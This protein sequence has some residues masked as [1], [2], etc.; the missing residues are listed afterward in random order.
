M[1]THKEKNIYEVI[2]ETNDL[3]KYC[4]S[5]GVNLVSIGISY[6]DNSPFTGANN[7]FRIDKNEPDYW[8]DHSL[9]KGGDVIDFCAL[10]KHDGDKHAALLELAPE[11]YSAKIDKY[12]RDKQSVQDYIM[13]A[14]KNIPEYII[15]YLESRC[16]DREQINR[17][18][19][20]CRAELF[21]NWLVIPRVNY[22]GDFQYYRLRRAPDEQGNENETLQPEKYKCAYIGDNS[23]LKNIPLGIQTLDRKIKYLVIVEG[24]FDYLNFERERFAVIGTGGSSGITKEILQI[25]CDNADN[26][27]PVLAFDNDDAGKKYTLDGANLLFKRKIN[28][29]V[30]V[31][32]DNCKDIND[33]YKAGGDLNKLCENATPGL[34]Y[35]A[36]SLIPDE[37]FNMLSRGR[38]NTLKKNIKDFFIECRRIGADNADIQTLC[39]CLI[40]RGLPDKWLAEI[41]NKSERG[42][43]EFEISQ[44]LQEQHNLLFNE[45]TGFYEYDTES[46]SW[47][48]IADKAISQYIYNYLGH[49][50]TARKI[51]SAVDITKSAVNSDIPEKHFNRKPL[52]PFKNGTLHLDFSKGKM[53]LL[54]ATPSD[55]VTYRLK[56]DFTIGAKCDEWLDTLQVIFAGDERRINCLQEFCG[57]IWLPDCRFQKALCL[58]GDGSNGKSLILKVLRELYNPENCTNLGLSS[59]AKDFQLIRLKDALINIGF[60]NKS[61]IADA[62]AN[63]KSIIAGDSVEACEK[64]KPYINFISR[65]KLILAINNPLITIDKSYAMLR[66]FLLIDC[67]VKFVNNPEENNPLQH[68]IDSGLEARLIT[69]E[70][71]SGIFIWTWQGLARLIK[72]NGEFTATAEQDEISSAFVS[73]TDSIDNFVAE[74]NSEW[75]GKKYTR[76]EIYNMYLEYCEI[77]RVNNIVRA[78]DNF[79]STLN[80][81][82]TKNKV[83]TKTGQK[84]DGTR[85]Y[86]FHSRQES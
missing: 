70:I 52:I 66:R 48:K 11:G 31:L 62:E 38:Q 36:E 65:V 73:K 83:L 56:Y 1:K 61:N 16:V 17:L 4:E 77:A 51:N 86:E 45:K 68:K 44:H 19:L 58:R 84:H 12:F 5:C 80:Q 54:S 82:L 43:S 10:L 79:F 71:L 60:E 18:K 47:Q 27:I 46:E 41:K 8:Y 7:A 49:E 30:V 9:N 72:N 14:Y 85:Y 22:D 13:G 63:L 29:F 2:R 59:F 20:G 28:F 53:E 34:E 75:Q 33:Y 81:A 64:L 15:K 23:F 78:E 24:D 35:I 39:E 42:D 67:P 76:D 55:Y 6:R 37:D 50:A 69:P 74:C 3:K 26:K 57:Y 21:K 40:K 25:I 32:P